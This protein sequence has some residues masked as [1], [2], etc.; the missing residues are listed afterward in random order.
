[1]N[2][3][4]VQS[5]L[6]LLGVLKAFSAQLLAEALSQFLDRHPKVTVDV[7]LSDKFADLVDDNIDIAI[8][9][10]YLKDSGLKA[11]WLLD[12][13]LVYFAAPSYLD[14][15]SPIEHAIDLE[16]HQCLTYSLATPSNVWYFPVKDA[17]Q[18]VKVNEYI[19]SDSPEMLVQMARLGQGV[20]AMPRWMIEKDLSDGRLIQVLADLSTLKRPMYLVYKNVEHQPQRIRAFIDFL[21]DYFISTKANT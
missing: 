18:K 7:S 2:L 3:N 6:R 20:A 11:K 14:A 19:R 8:R 10:S 21:S 15:H 13:E 1:M 16:K 17:V 5:K 9:A 12:N 4:C